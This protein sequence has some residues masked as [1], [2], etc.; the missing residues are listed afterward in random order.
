MEERR[1]CSHRCSNK[2]TCGHECCKI[3]VSIKSSAKKHVA[4]KT[5]KASDKTTTNRRHDV[6]TSAFFD[7]VQNP[8]HRMPVN[9][10]SNCKH[11]S[12]SDELVCWPSHCVINC[13]LAVKRYHWTL[14][15]GTQEKTQLKSFMLDFERF[16][17]NRVVKDRTVSNSSVPYSKTISPEGCCDNNVQAFHSCSNDDFSLPAEVASC[18]GKNISFTHPDFDILSEYVIVVIFESSFHICVLYY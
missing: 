18:Q 6:T 10:S 16:R 12:V 5:S 3:G 14:Q 13:R 9:T 11:S 4:C 1:T 15:V 8:I 2:A 17:Y 7:G